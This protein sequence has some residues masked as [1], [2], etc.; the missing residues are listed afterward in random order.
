M[1]VQPT[2]APVRMFFVAESLSTATWNKRA[3]DAGLLLD[4]CRIID[5]GHNISKD[6]LLKIETWSRAATEKELSSTLD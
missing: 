4:R 1:S 2:V 6:V 5:Y 3:L